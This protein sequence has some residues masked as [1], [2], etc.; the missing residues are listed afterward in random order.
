MNKLKNEEL[1][2]LTTP[3]YMWVTFKYDRAN[4]KSIEEGMAFNING[5]EVVF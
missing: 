1:D 4:D 3:N 5:E 2:S